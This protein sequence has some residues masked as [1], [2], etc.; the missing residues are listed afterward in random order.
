MIDPL[1]ESTIS[2]TR[3]HKVRYDFMES[4]ALLS[5]WFNVMTNKTVVPLVVMWICNL[6]ETSSMASVQAGSFYAVSDVNRLALS[7][8]ILLRNLIADV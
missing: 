6:M 5:R 7:R 8:N 1:K 2:V 3:R 4:A